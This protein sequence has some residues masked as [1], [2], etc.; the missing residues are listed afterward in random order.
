M[1]RALRPPMSQTMQRQLM[2]S[3]DT[4]IAFFTATAIFAFIPGPG[5]LYAA[6]PA[7]AAS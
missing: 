7:R 6:A 5:L 3:S 1:T 2:P 4:L